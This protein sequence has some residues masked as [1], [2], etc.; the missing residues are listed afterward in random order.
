MPKRDSALLSILRREIASAHRVYLQDGSACERSL[1][2]TDVLVFLPAFQSMTVRYIRRDGAQRAGRSWSTRFYTDRPT[3]E[4]L[5]DW[6]A[7]LKEADGGKVT[8][9]SKEGVG[10]TFRFSLPTKAK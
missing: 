4:A 9:D 8:V 1:T 10:S 2:E 5:Y 6:L 3:P 7:S